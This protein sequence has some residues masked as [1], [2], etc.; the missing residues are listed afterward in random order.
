MNASTLCLG[1]TEDA[2][3]I[4]LEGKG[5]RRESEHL[6]SL[7]EEVVAEDQRTQ[8]SR[9]FVVMLDRCEY[10]DSTFLGG[11]VR[12]A[13]RQRSGQA[14][15][16]I[17]ATPATVERLL[18]PCKLQKYLPVHSSFAGQLPDQWH[19]VDLDHPGDAC[20]YHQLETHESLA[21][22]DIPQSAAFQRIAESIR[23]ELQARDS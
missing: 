11:L 14:D 2:V 1:R 23:K 15:L 20:V 17:V 22:L 19:V 3:V 5:L 21:E 7:Y 6:K 12:L 13:K 4:I 8:S 16:R 9:S 10:L 18:G